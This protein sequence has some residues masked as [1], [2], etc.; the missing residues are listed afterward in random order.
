MHPMMYLTL[1]ILQTY[2]V[3]QITNYTIKA[4]KIAVKQFTIIFSHVHMSI[5]SV[6]FANTDKNHFT[7]I[8]T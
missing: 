7:I 8:F 6:S 3:K 1:N 5:N 2:G 4:A